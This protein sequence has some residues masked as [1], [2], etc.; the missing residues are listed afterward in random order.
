MK[1]LFMF[2]ILAFSMLFT[3]T[4]VQAAAPLCVFEAN[5][6]TYLYFVNGGKACGYMIDGDDIIS[7]GCGAFGSCPT[8]MYP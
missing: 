5:G 8:A 7:L 1:K 2:G 3:P 4:I 6:V